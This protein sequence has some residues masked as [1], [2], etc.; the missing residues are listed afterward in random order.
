LVEILPDGS[1]ILV[2]ASPNKDWI[3]WVVCWLG[4]ILVDGRDSNGSSKS[5]KGGGGDSL[6]GGGGGGRGGGGRGGGIRGLRLN[7]GKVNVVSSKVG[8]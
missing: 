7:I 6:G 3:S 2:I 8:I 1:N 5:S 4:F